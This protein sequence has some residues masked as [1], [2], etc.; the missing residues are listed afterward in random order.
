MAT[1][2]IEEVL[3]IF[4]IKEV[5]SDNVTLKLFYKASFGFCL[6]SSLLVTATQYWGNPIECAQSASNPIDAK[7]FERNCWIH[8]TERIEKREDQEHF[9]C[10]TKVII[11]ILILSSSNL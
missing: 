7:V 4:K 3:G 11:L 1:N 10:I 5:N 8:G 2:I 9:N 6:F